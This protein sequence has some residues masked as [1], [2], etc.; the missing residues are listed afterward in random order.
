MTET[1]PG[2]PAQSTAQTEDAL[3]AALADIRAHWPALLEGGSG[4]SQ[5]APS[6]DEVTPLDRRVSLRHEVTLTLNSWARVIVEDR[7]LTSCLPLGTDTLGLVTLIERH[8]R[9]FSGH[10]AA[11]DCLAELQ[12]AARQVRNTAAPSMRG[13]MHLGDC[14]FAVGLVRVAHLPTTEPVL[15]DDHAL[16]SDC[17]QIGPTLWW[18]EVI[19][20]KC[21]EEVPRNELPE[22]IYNAFGRRVSRPTL[23][24][25]IK[26]GELARVDY[27]RVP[28]WFNRAQVLDAVTVKWLA[29]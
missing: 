4:G 20:G 5:G 28:E 15:D 29:S 18:E 16:C 2:G 21:R 13:W 24:R 27:V 1:A 6:S 26:S 22:L 3:L 17:G 19:T 14:P 7:P 8:A 9:W 12:E 23:H 11:H 10:E 25:W